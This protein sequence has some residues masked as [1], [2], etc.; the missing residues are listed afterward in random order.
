MSH[1]FRPSIRPYLKYRSCSFSTKLEQI[2][3]EDV[4]QEM[5]TEEKPIAPAIRYNVCRQRNTSIPQKYQFPKPPQTEEQKAMEQN[6]MM[7]DQNSVDVQKVVDASK[8]LVPSSNYRQF[9]ASS[10][11]K[12]LVLPLKS[13]KLADPFPSPVKIMPSHTVSDQEKAEQMLAERRIPRNI[14]KRK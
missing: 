12:N 1:H 5:E 3:S 7:S 10:T 9:E 11:Y 8:E 2:L 13:S 14:T 4:A 6:K